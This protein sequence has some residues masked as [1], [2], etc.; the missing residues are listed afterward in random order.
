MDDRSFDCAVG[1]GILRLPDDGE[2]RERWVDDKCDG[3]IGR[4]EGEPFLSIGTKPMEEVR[5]LGEDFPKDHLRRSF[6]DGHRHIT[7]RERQVRRDFHHLNP[8]D[9]GT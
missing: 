5:M 8:R 2:G 6:E 4:P 1:C 7:D 9:G 3:Q